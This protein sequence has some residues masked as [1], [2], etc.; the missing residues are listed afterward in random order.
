MH[1]FLHHTADVRL[2]VRADSYEEL[3]R[4]A[5]QALFDFVVGAASRT[6]DSRSFDVRVDAP[7]HTFLLVDFL[8]EALTLSHIHRMV[9]TVEALKVDGLEMTATLR[10]ATPERFSEDVKAVTYHE[11]EVKEN[12]DGSWQTQLVFD[13]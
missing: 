12:A 1:E 5:L 3:V 6:D 8:N 9:F 4:E 11:A 10:G 13:I 7:D 2:A